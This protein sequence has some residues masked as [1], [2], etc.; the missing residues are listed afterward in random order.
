MEKKRKERGKVANG[1]VKVKVKVSI[2]MHVKKHKPRSKHVEK[3]GALVEAIL[4]LTHTHTHR[5]AVA[6]SV[7]SAANCSCCTPRVNI[8]KGPVDSVVNL[9]KIKTFHSTSSTSTAASGPVQLPT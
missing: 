5:I 4:P 3:P 1:K 8:Q 9:V 7:S 6:S 2:M